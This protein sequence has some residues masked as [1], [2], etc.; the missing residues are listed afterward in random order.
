M[1]SARRSG[2]SRSLPFYAGI[3]AIVAGISY[4]AWVLEFPLRARVDPVDGYVSELS[5]VDQPWHW[6]FSAGDLVSGVL[7]IAAA[8]LCLICLERRGWS[9]LGWGF[10]MAFG[11]FAIGDAVFTMDCAPSTD[12]TCALRER[13]G[14]VSFSHEFHDVTSSLVIAFG[15]AALLALGIAARQ[16]RPWSSLARWGPVLAVAEAITALATLLLMYLGFWLGLVQRVQITILCVGL[17]L[18][19]TELYTLSAPLPQRRERSSPPPSQ[20]LMGRPG[21]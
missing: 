7:A 4:S 2:I 11:F 20:L 1:D 17:L 19:G 15:I 16:Y 21:G 12:T 8:V 13:A 18:I 5:A 3:F 9:L 6:L 14:L 10:L